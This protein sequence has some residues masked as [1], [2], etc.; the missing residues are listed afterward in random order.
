MYQSELQRLAKTG[1]P[2]TEIELAQ[3]W[4]QFVGSRYKNKSTLST[5][6]G[7]MKKVLAELLQLTQVDTELLTKQTS[8]IQTV[9]GTQKHT[10]YNINL[11]L[12]YKKMVATSYRETIK[13]DSVIDGKKVE[14]EQVY[15][16]ISDKNQYQDWKDM[17]DE[18]GI[19]Q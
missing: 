19:E 14:A 13:N 1:K 10:Y 12:T 3:A 7:K 16:G 17:E 2:V 8:K 6:H 4:E 9:E 18:L 5:Y 15:H 11:N